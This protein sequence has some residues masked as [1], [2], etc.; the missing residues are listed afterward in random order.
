MIFFQLI[1]QPKVL[2]KASFEGLSGST[3]MHLYNKNNE[4][5]I[6]MQVVDLDVSNLKSV[7]LEPQIPL[8]QALQHD[9]VKTAVVKAKPIINSYL[10]DKP[11]L[12]PKEAHLAISNPEI[13][14]HHTERSNGYVQ[15]A[16]FCT[17]SEYYPEDS[18]KRCQKNSNLCHPRDNRNDVQ[19]VI[20][21][22]KNF[23]S[24]EDK[25]A[26]N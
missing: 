20:D 7:P 10:S 17:C 25:K 13:T 3:T 6:Y 2:F 23:I 4:L 19:K 26:G 5:G 18:E 11:L 9:L 14:M 15:L 12:L 21:T 8:P 16:I 22:V 1:R 24:E